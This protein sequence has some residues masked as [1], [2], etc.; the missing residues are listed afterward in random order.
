MAGKSDIVD[1]VASATGLTKKDASDALDAITDSIT[2]SLAD[3]DRVQLPNFGSFSIS[4]RAAREGRNPATG[5]TIQIPA[6]K[7][8]RFKAGKALKDAVND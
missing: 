3:G 8:V 2:A 7:N 5:D 4:E 1:A 6:S